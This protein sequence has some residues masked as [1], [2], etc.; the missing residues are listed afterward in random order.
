MKIFITGIA[1]FLG[2]HLA[3]ALIAQGHE[4]QGNDNMIGGDKDN[5]AHLFETHK[6]YN[7]DCNDLGEMMTIFEEFKPDVV[8]HCAALA[9]EGLSV[10]SPKTITDSIYGA[11]LS[12]LSASIANGVKRF[13]FCS[14]MARYGN[15][16]GQIDLKRGFTEDLIPLPVD[17]YGSAKHSAENALKIICEAHGMEYVILVPHNIIGPRQKY[18]D[19]FRNVA[20]IM[21]NRMIQGLQPIIYGDGNQVR[22]FSFVEDCIQCLVRALDVRSGEIINIGPDE[23]EVTI[24]ELATAISDILGFDLNPIYV[25]ERPQEVKHAT[26][27]SD[28]AR[29]LL[30]YKTNFTLDVGLR[31]LVDYIKQR[32]P[33]PF[34]YHLPL[35][36]INDKTPKTWTEKLI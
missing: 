8:Y 24:N 23:G 7:T 17:P 21:T 25:P 2:S 18:D 32:G 19:P 15:K 9:H 3:D 13:I 1:G 30:G 28:K 14:S 34:K 5:I 26:C 10:F 4:V 22:C 20:S 6:L 35:E 27:C 31:R 11:T 29:S 12:T 16:M 33:K 36:I